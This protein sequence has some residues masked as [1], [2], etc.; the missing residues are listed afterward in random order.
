MKL[1]FLGTSHGK[2]EYKRAMTAMALE[3]RGATYLIDAGAPVVNRMLDYGID[4]ESVK[5]VFIT[6]THRDHVAG[7][8]DL[9]RVVNI[10]KIFES[11]SIDYY[12]PE[13]NAIL[14]IKEYAASIMQPVR[15]DVNRFHLFAEGEIYKDENIRVTAIPT[16]HLANANRPAY[17]F[18]VECEGK[19][20]LFSGDLSQ[21]L[22]AGDFPRIASEVDIDLCIQ[23][24]AHFDLETLLPN[25]IDSK[26]KA[27]YF[28][29]MVWHAD[30]IPKIRAA[31]KDGRLKL[32]VGIAND[33]DVIYL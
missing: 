23:E 8:L 6:H 4:I 18:L 25:L 22:L 12:F 13:Q 15:E 19:R 27:V 30:R 20:L 3:T 10:D 21:R 16:A 24:M 26:I 7:L 31:Q 33:G 9:V 29:H 5:A 11:A 32:D 28:N 1:T 2:P 17:A 14:A